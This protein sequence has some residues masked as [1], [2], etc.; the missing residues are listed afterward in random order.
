MIKLWARTFTENAIE[1]NSNAH[2]SDTE[3]L[4]AYKIYKQPAGI[5]SF[6]SKVTSSRR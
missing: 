4:G 3:K 2:K 1:N 6:S 5:P